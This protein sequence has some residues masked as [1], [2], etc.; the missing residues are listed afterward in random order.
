M[1]PPLTN[2]LI[3]Q[4]SMVKGLPKKTSSYKYQSMLAM[5]VHGMFRSM[6]FVRHPLSKRLNKAYGLL[7]KRAIKYSL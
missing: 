7:L 3:K 5:A 1:R 2:D 4:K 6:S